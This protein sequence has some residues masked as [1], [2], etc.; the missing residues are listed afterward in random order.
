MANRELLLSSTLECG[1]RRRL[2]G[3]GRPGR[4]ERCGEIERDS[5]DL[6]SRHGLI[7]LEGA[8]VTFLSWDRG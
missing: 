4:E 8:A 3:P 2:D 1:V 6:S 5:G 7:K